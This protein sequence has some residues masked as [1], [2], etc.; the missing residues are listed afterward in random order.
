LF[1]PPDAEEHEHTPYGLAL[2][3]WEIA[4]MRS[5]VPV[6]EFV[7]SAPEAQNLMRSDDRA[8]ADIVEQSVSIPANVQSVLGVHAYNFEGFVDFES[9]RVFLNEYYKEVRRLVLVRGSTADCETF[10]LFATKEMG[11]NAG[12]HSAAL[13]MKPTQQSKVVVAIP[14][15]ENG[16][17]GVELSTEVHCYSVRIDSALASQ[18]KPQLRRVRETH[19][20]AEW[21]LGWIHGRL[22]KEENAQLQ[23][24]SFGEELNSRRKR[25]REDLHAPLLVP[26]RQ[27]GSSDGQD[28]SEKETKEEMALDEGSVFIG[29]VELQKLRL[30]QRAERRPQTVEAHLKAPMIIV[31]TSS[32]VR[33]ADASDI[34]IESVAS[35]AS[36]DVRQQ[37]YR[38]FSH[39]L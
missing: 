11:F 14:A 31:G 38:C 5:I 24:N 8:P 19:G 1:P 33:Y 3:A 6:K 30:A 22:L 18:V 29:T 34:T 27:Q 7:D 39:I 20:G 16:A 32:Y 37:V 25:A 28:D 26:A 2:K 35:P 4:R 21:E 15:L 10:L 13:Q 36:F 23:P 17:I 9:A 12:A